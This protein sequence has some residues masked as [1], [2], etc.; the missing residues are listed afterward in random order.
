MAAMVATPAGAPVLM[1][2]PVLMGQPARSVAI[3]PIPLPWPALAG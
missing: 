3:F 1:G 2:H